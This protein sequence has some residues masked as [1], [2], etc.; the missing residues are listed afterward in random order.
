MTTYNIP[1]EIRD[2]LKVE[3]SE[4]PKGTP[5]EDPKKDPTGDTGTN[6]K[7]ASEGAEGEGNGPSKGDPAG[8]NKEPTKPAVPTSVKLD[9]KEYG[10]EDLGRIVKEHQ[11]NE[12]WNKVNT[13]KA[14]KLS[15]QANAIESVSGPLEKL[16]QDEETLEILED[17]GHKLDKKALS[18]VK[19][20]A[21]DVQT[22]PDRD[23]K[24]EANEDL[25]TMQ[26]EL[27]DLKFMEALREITG[28]DEDHQ[29]AIGT[30][31]KRQAFLKFMVENDLP[32]LDRAYNLYTQAER[33]KE[34][35]AAL[36]E[37]E[38]KGGK[39]TKP[40]KAPVGPG[41]KEIKTDFQPVHKDFGYDAAREAT[42][43]SLNK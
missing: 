28:R 4:Q 19:E 16:L 7:G 18:A 39:K 27:N 43:K 21:K 8:K 3:E 32:D 2:S 34:A 38:E 13:E 20:A 11:K 15:A 14:Q 40:K 37:A 36:K 17:M 12:N 10:L 30:P 1:Q 33:L 25:E 9:G 42:L 31:E 23:K 26:A 41:A 5:A 24:P 35:E 29:K 6:V 22:N